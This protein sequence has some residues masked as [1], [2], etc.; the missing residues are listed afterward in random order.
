M[1]TKKPP[2]PRSRT[3]KRYAKKMARPISDVGGGQGGMLTTFGSAG[4]FWG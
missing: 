3:Q 4:S 2:R 1:T